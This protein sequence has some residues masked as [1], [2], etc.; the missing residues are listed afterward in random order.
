[1]PAYVFL[2][3]TMPAAEARAI[4]DARVLP[5]VRQGDVYRLVETERPAA[6]GIVDGTFQHVPAV[7]HKEI[8]WALECGVHVVGAASMG[9]LRA[10]E[11]EAFG[12]RGVG[13]VFRAYRDGV[14][15]GYDDEAFEDDDEVAVI[16]GPAETGYLQLSEALVNIRVTL[17][18]AEA[19]GVLSS[20]A[21][22]RL[23]T[24]AKATFYQ[25]R[26]YDGLIAAASKQGLSPQEIEAFAAWLP[27]GR[28]D[29][30]REDARSLLLA[31]KAWLE[32][33]RV[34]ERESCGFAHTT[35]WQTAIE[36]LQ[37]PA[38]STPAIGASD[39]GT[40]VAALSALVWYFEDRLGQ[41]IPD[42]LERYATAQGYRDHQAFR[43][44]VVRDYRRARLAGGS[45]GR[46]EAAE[47]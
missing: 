31:V 17:C 30:K 35:L 36:R 25:D 43:D 7:W 44:A 4:C 15:P 6:I 32:G 19:A 21:R 1:M 40:G 3:P 33:D 47:A 2:G 23:A 37:A 10:A 14:L 45:D 9:A 18:A 20:V 42:D 29:Q 12:M 34:P 41:A 39:I 24:I 46:G 11:L 16:H 13:V 5:P 22:K 38:D 8:L 27:Q 26:S 28:V